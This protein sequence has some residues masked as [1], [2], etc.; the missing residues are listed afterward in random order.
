M[1]SWHVAAS[2]EGSLICQKFPKIPPSFQNRRPPAAL[3]VALVIPRA[4]TEAKRPES[5]G[6]RNARSS[7]EEMGLR[8]IWRQMT[9]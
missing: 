7:V 3:L 6:K 8:V 2:S 1:P 5:T 9:P 4:H